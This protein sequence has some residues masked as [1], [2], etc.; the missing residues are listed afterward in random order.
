MKSYGTIP[1]LADSYNKSGYIQLFQLTSTVL[2]DIYEDG[3]KNGHFR[4]PDLATL[5]Q[6]SPSIWS[7]ITLCLIGAVV[8]TIFRVTFGKAFLNVSLI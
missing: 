4:L 7:D 1:P 5:L 2:Q 8:L 6:Y 3:Q